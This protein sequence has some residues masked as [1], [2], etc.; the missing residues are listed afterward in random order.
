[1]RCDSLKMHMTFIIIRL[2]I[3][4][5]DLTDTYT[6]HNADF[7]NPSILNFYVSMK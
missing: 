5:Y 7:R 2:V 3:H 6:A 4:D 1:M